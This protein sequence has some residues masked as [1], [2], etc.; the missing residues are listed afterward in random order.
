MERWTFIRVRSRIASKLPH[1]W[2]SS[3]VFSLAA[4]LELKFNCKTSFA[5]AKRYL[6]ISQTQYESIVSILTVRIAGHIRVNIIFLWKPFA[7][8]WFYTPHLR[9]IT[10][11]QGCQR[12]GG[13]R[14]WPK[15]LLCNKNQDFNI[16]RYFQLLFTRV[17]KS[18]SRGIS[19]IPSNPH[20]NRKINASLIY[21]MSRDLHIIPVNT[22][23]PSDP[24][25]VKLVFVVWCHLLSSF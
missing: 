22:I 10:N 11:K 6:C 20:G 1:V 8:H 13:H 9:T 3:L 2:W 24:F 16:S 18:L 5:K 19:C 21:W 12:K 25:S 17:E 14:E 23:P 15:S 4:N 7:R